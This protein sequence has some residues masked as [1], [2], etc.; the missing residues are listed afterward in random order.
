MPE[1][2][3]EQ[4]IES[5]M[6]GFDEA[7]KRMRRGLKQDM[8]LRASA[9]GSLKICGADA[10]TGQTAAVLIFTWGESM[11][12]AVAGA[13]EQTVTDLGL[14]RYVVGGEGIIQ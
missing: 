7:V 5:M 6:K 11:S 3:R 14:K 1:V 8:E 4:Y 10:A 13:H 2:T 12:K 9:E